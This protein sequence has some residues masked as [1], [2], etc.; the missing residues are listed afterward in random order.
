MLSMHLRRFLRGEVTHIIMIYCLIS[1]LLYAF[2]PSGFAVNWYHFFDPLK[3]GFVPYIDFQA[4]YPI[5]GFLPYGLL[6]FLLPVDVYVYAMRYLNLLL[7]VISI[8]TLYKVVKEVRE[9][10]DALFTSLA[11]ML[12]AS[13]LIANPYSNDSIALFF[14]SLTLLSLIKKHEVLSGILLSLAILA[15][16]YP[17]FLLSI[18][19]AFFKKRTAKIR[20]LISLSLSFLLINLPFLVINPYMWAETF[21]GGN[22]GRGP[23]E[24]IF[25]LIDGYYSHGGVE[26]IHPYF[27]GFLAYKQLMKIYPLSHN[28]HAFYLYRYNFIPLIMSILL[29]LSFIIPIVLFTQEKLLE[30]IGLSG[31]LFFTAS[32]GYSPEFSIFT[33]PLLALSI[34]SKKKIIFTT[35]TDAATILQMLNW[36]GWFTIIKE[37]TILPYA[38]ILRTVTFITAMIVLLNL[39]KRSEVS[40]SEIIIL[41]A[42]SAFKELVRFIMVLYFNKRALGGILILT[43][44]FFMAF[45]EAYGN[46]DYRIVEQHINLKLSTNGENSINVNHDLKERIYIIFPVLL[47]ITVDANNSYIQVA[48]VSNTTRVFIVPKSEGVTSIGMKLVYPLAA[49]SVK[50]VLINNHS[51]VVQGFVKFYQEENSLVISAN[52]P[53]QDKYYFLYISWPVEININEKTEI[54]VSLTHINGSFNRV[55][56]DLIDKNEKRNVFGYEIA[57]GYSEAG[58]KWHVVINC[59]SVD[60]FGNKFRDIYGRKVGAINLVLILNPNASATIKLEKLLYK[61]DNNEYALSLTILDTTIQEAKI[62]LGKFFVL[63][64]YYLGALTWGSLIILFLYIN[65]LAR[66]MKH[67]GTNG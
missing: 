16:I 31:L 60:A 7:L 8:Y 49:F 15:K 48:Y 4:G 41:H 39:I 3:E 51:Q 38:V 22:A 64:N 9:R 13:I 54:D 6:A 37:G 61:V 67:E 28:D 59:S 20:L 56:L 27:E 63:H 46:Y 19:L 23:W 11:I 36:S 62:Y 57:P 25:A 35:L 2:F 43:I 52:N 30:I 53:S 26:D 5:M 32:K 42:K 66:R 45:H 21:I 55:I 47:P 17:I 14:F 12:S 58:E 34:P 18:V 40:I 33:I 24:T 44:I 50:E 1:A 29:L 65:H 10:Q